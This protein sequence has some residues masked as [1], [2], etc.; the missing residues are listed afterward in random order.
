MTKCVSLQ[1]ISV[2]HE[3]QEKKLSACKGDLNV[4][5]IS[6]PYQRRNVRRALSHVLRNT[7]N[8]RWPTPFEKCINTHMGDRSK[9]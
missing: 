5:N 3:G 7:N 9:R 6:S 1:S 8:S 4:T 2:L